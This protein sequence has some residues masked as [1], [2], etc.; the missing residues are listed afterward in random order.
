MDPQSSLPPAG[1]PRRLAAAVY[2]LLLLAGVLVI[3]TALTWVVRGGREVPPGTHWFQ[4]ALVGVAALFFC[5]FWTH[6]G[7]TV[8]MLAWKLRL[9]R[10]DGTPVGWREALV[11]FA[12]AIVSLAPLGLGFLWAL[13]DRDALTWH[14]RLSRT[15]VVHVELGSNRFS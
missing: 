8:G 1:L 13:V 9:V 4:L 15:R 14:D 11:R 3:F 2:D 5:W 6:G 10:G 12:A 7:Q